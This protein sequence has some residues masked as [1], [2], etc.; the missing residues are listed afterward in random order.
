M[1]MTK[2]VK[3]DIEE[4]ISEGVDVFLARWENAY[5]ETMEETKAQK[6]LE[7][8]EKIADFVRKRLKLEVFDPN[9]MGWNQ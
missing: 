8:M 5:P 3:E 1:R 9:K 4:L 6:K 2:K 7:H